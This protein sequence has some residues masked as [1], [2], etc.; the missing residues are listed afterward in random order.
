M[1]QIERKRKISGTSIDEALQR[2]RQFMEE[3]EEDKHFHNCADVDIL[4]WVTVK[5]EEQLD[6][7]ESLRH[8]LSLYL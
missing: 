1:G 5:L 2:L 8:L 4:N 7:I 3:H 6:Q